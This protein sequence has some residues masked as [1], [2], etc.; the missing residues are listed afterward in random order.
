MPLSDYQKYELI[1]R[2]GLNPD[3]YTVDEQQ[4]L[5]VPKQT[6][7]PPAD[8]DVST[9]LLGANVSTPK[10]SDLESASR[11]ATEN[12]IPGLSSAG[13]AALASKIPGPWYVKAAA[14]LIGAFGVGSA[15]HV[16][17][18]K[19][20]P[21]SI[22]QKIF[23][24]PEDYAENPI[25]TTLGSLVNP[26]FRPSIRGTK[27][28]YSAIKNAPARLLEQ[29]RSGLTAAE[30]DAL[31]NA[32]LNVLP[33]AGFEA[34]NYA[35]DP[36]KYDAGLGLLRTLPQALLTHP[37]R[38]GKM[39]GFTAGPQ[40]QLGR[41]APEYKGPVY[42]P[43]TFEETYPIRG[44]PV[45]DDSQRPPAAE[46]VAEPTLEES[47]IPAPTRVSGENLAGRQ[48]AAKQKIV[49]EQTKQLE[50][51]AEQEAAKTEAIAKGTP[52]QQELLSEQPARADYTLEELA[53]QEAAAR[54]PRIDE[55][56]IREQELPADQES[57]ANLRKSF[58]AE[59]AKRGFKVK[60]VK[61]LFSSKSGKQIAG[62]I[63]TTKREIE[64]NESLAGAD[65]GPHEVGHGFL[66]DLVR[67]G[68]KRDRDLAVR[69]LELATG[70]KMTAEEFLA[71]P[72]AE[73]ARLEEL[74]MQ[75]MVGPEGAKQRATSLYGNRRKQF[76]QWWENTKSHWK[77][78]TGFDTPEDVTRFFVSRMR[79]DAPYGT[80]PEL[81]TAE[82]YKP[83]VSSDQ[84]ESKGKIVDVVD[85]E[86]GKSYKFRYDGDQDMSIIGRGIQRQFTAQEDNP[87]VPN[88]GTTYEETLKKGGGQIREQSD[89]PVLGKEGEDYGPKIE[90][91]LGEA[92]F[93]AAKDAEGMQRKKV[94]ETYTDVEVR[95]DIVEELLSEL[96]AK[97]HFVKSTDAEQR[98]LVEDA[99]KYVLGDKTALDKYESVVGA[100]TLDEI[101]NNAFR[102]KQSYEAG[103][104]EVKKAA[105]EA[106]TKANQK[107][108]ELEAFTRPDVERQQ[109]TPMLPFGKEQP[110]GDE[111]D[112]EAMRNKSI[113]RMLN[114]IDTGIYK[115]KNL[116]IISRE[117][118]Q[119][120]RDAFHGYDI[121]EKQLT[122]YVD[123][124]N[125]IYAMQ[126]NGKGMDA[127]TFLT[128]Y[129]PPITSGKGVGE[130]GGF[131]LAKGIVLGRPE[132]FRIVTTAPDPKT[133]ELMT[134]TLDGTGEAWKQY[135]KDFLKGKLPAEASNYDFSKIEF[136]DNLHA[137]RRLANPDEQRGT[138]Y[139]L[140]D[141]SL[142]FRELNHA[143]F[144]VL[145]PS[146]K[147]KT[148]NTNLSNTFDSHDTSTFSPAEPLNYD[149]REHDRP[150]TKVY[151]TVSSPN[152]DIE[153]LY[154]PSGPQE[155]ASNITMHVSSNGSYQFSK[156]MAVG[157]WG[158]KAIL[159][160]E[161]VMNVLPKVEAENENY[162][163][164]INRDDVKYEVNSLMKRAFKDAV[165]KARQSIQNSYHDVFDPKNKI[166]TREGY[167]VANFFKEITQ[168]E[169]NTVESNAPV[170]NNLAK[171]VID[172]YSIFNKTL[173]KVVKESSMSGGRLM[174]TAPLEEIASN[175]PGGITTH[176]GVFGINAYN[177]V[178]KRKETFINPFVIAKTALRIYEHPENY[179]SL[180]DI[181]ARL[182]I[183][184]AAHEVTHNV[185]QGEGEALSRAFTFLK[186]DEAPAITKHYKKLTKELLDLPNLEEQVA[187]LKDKYDQYENYDV[188]T[189]HRVFDSG[190][191]REAWDKPGTQILSEKNERTLSR[192]EEGST[193]GSPRERTDTRNI[194]RES[195]AAELPAESPDTQPKE[196]H[197]IWKALSS[198]TQKIRHMGS[199]AA[200]YVADKGELYSNERDLNLG[201][202]RN[203]VQQVITEYP[204][205][206]RANVDQYGREM[207]LRGESDITLNDQE[208][209]LYDSMRAYLSTVADENTLREIKRNPNYWP[210]ILSTRVAY[211]WANNA[212]SPEAKRYKN[213]W[214]EHARAKVA[215]GEAQYN[216]DELTKILEDY[217]N[218]VRGRGEPSLQFGALRKAAGLGLPES[219]QDNN[220]LSRF[221]RYG[222]R[223]A[224]DLAYHK[225]LESDPFMR[226]A[227]RIADSTGAK[228]RT[229]P[230]GLEG[231]EDI[232]ETKQIDDFKRFIFNEFHTIEYPKLY[233]AGRL[234][235]SALLGTATGARNLL[236]SPNNILPFIGG[237]RNLRALVDGATQLGDAS[238]AS[239]EYNARQK[240]INELEFGAAASP[241]T[242]SRWFNEAADFFRKWSGRNMADQWERTYMFSVARHAA[243]AEFGR[244]AD[245]DVK[246]QEWLKKYGTT[247]EN[248]EKHWNGE[249]PITEDAI[250][251]I[252][253]EVT[254]AAAGSYDER[255]L[256]LWAVESP[257]APFLSLSRWSIERA[258]RVANDIV[259]PAIEKGEY[260]PLLTYALGSVLTG[261]AIKK[262]NE[263]ISG[264]KRASEPSIS[265]AL[266]ANNN[267]EAVR[268]VIGLAQLGSLG[269]MV[270]DTVK[271]GADLATGH[272]PTLGLSYPL[273]DFIATGLGQNMADYAAALQAGEPGF[274][275]TLALIA[276]IA[277]D[278]IQT[279]RLGAQLGDPKEIERKNAYRDVR[280]WKEL[281]GQQEPDNTLGRANPFVNR[282]E[283]EFKKEKDL[284]RAAEML[285]AVLDRQVKKAKGSTEELEKN[286]SN[287][288]RNSY[289]TFPSDDK[290]MFEYYAYL[291]QTQGEEEAK[292]RLADYLTQKDV[293]K[294]KSKMIP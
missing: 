175:K 189:E 148:V 64:L 270:G 88:R 106:F 194:E 215:S 60:Y 69:G 226:Y 200:N 126:D 95:D 77:F 171:A 223:V 206:V 247:V 86:T 96:Q 9:P 282:Q 231:L 207:M 243:L 118:V 221:S 63:N 51:Q 119:N 224:R 138:V 213:E 116:G 154:D 57:R 75:P 278:S 11:S 1:R 183:N 98:P 127:K 293:N 90:A 68:A 128:K 232:P 143:Q 27:N 167:T 50:L 168:D 276:Q 136:N 150:F 26:A 244:A 34:Y 264:G 146:Y 197:I 260:G 105:D 99:S 122:D 267:A 286:L 10:P 22:Q 28:L 220:L 248:I 62:R 258:N 78:K 163:F 182:S 170:I 254:T 271:W 192:N 12:L 277:R 187:Y 262:L 97:G 70:K 93:K 101:K 142:D 164:T 139:M 49:E 155:E 15:A 29:G 174:E 159:P 246:A 178:T 190:R 153:L 6:A 13:A 185:V 157:G 141:D 275:T 257:V 269:G 25:S 294:V 180:E 266:A 5:I 112:Y 56:P 186:S 263:L 71:L 114:L 292:R 181:L 67:S 237:T 225:V 249:A 87:W 47:L 111:P 76:Q 198:T 94:N 144:K 280:V 45:R 131:G 195:A 149:I 161:M 117:L 120:S 33:A 284:G 279:V 188:T 140:K 268:A 281:T 209:S 203:K 274:D 80:R 193:T 89:K 65:T 24:R 134:I 14:G 291:K 21:E 219:M 202:Y 129:L 252:A 35:Q 104:I 53:K 251:K 177:P 259:K 166:K 52:V 191:E 285:P 31:Y 199:Q 233:A 109:D 290:G 7:N 61:D 227:L 100:E 58:Q 44:L 158:Q 218:A 39:M 245:G 23:T 234:V 92:S 230:E 84:R 208:Q 265:E 240:N 38:I 42:G 273:A 253:K 17:Q 20:V 216:E 43:K 212:R 283:K 79:G 81:F 133:G 242:V 184:T 130:G 37:T 82:G 255:G 16:A 173:Q 222:S 85:P 137:Y 73:Q 239:F 211:M 19:L 66:A 147:A 124:V 4:Q 132:K 103:N 261:A 2:K 196:S 32:A 59:A 83:T 172:S 72:D 179:A 110:R 151:D 145:H 205:S 91:K 210:Q 55:A 228:M 113:E 235:N 287:L 236:Q 176:Q 241:D 165:E 229:K 135:A 169:I 217:V 123:S 152:F 162:P 272:K 214:M 250:N 288:K 18:E 121:P 102:Y 256:P 46:P 41:K 160:K 201:R 289:Q 238:K 74:W 36:E 54:G 40:E 156:E 8:T 204:E 115:G 108:E 107:A 48:L 30:A 125:K 3:E